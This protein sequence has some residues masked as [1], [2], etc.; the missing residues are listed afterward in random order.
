MRCAS[1]EIGLN[2]ALIKQE[3][4]I[5]EQANHWYKQRILHQR[6]TFVSS[7][8]LLKIHS[9]YLATYKATSVPSS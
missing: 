3:A 2:K 6:L 9:I 7:F 8:I 5:N 1:I 4:H